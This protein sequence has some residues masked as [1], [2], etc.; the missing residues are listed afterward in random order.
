LIS[1][2]GAITDSTP[3]YTWN[4]VSNSTWYYLWVNDSTGNRIKQWYTAAQVGCASGAGTCSVTPTTQLASGSGSWWIQTWNSAGTGL[5][6]TRLNFSV[7]TI[8]PPAA[9][10][11]ISPTGFISDS[12]PPYTWNAVSNST[13]YYLW[14]ND[15]SGNRIKYWYTAAEVGCASGTGICSVAPSTVLVNGS[16]NWSIQTWNAYG[17]GPWNSGMSFTIN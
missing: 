15:S 4:A 6:S 17:Y 8:G 5:W 7:S 11:A 1:P 14:V 10:S 12:T 9:A 3:T 13:W 2:S 16:A